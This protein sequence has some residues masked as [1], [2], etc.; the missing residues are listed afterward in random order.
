MPET[1]NSSILTQIVRLKYTTDTEKMY[2]RQL[3]I[4]F[5]G[6]AL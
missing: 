3:V 4:V 5:M 2:I 6:C 1:L